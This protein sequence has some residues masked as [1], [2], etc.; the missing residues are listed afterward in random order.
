MDAKVVAISKGN[1]RYGDALHFM[2]KSR[3]MVFFDVEKNMG[4]RAK[5]WSGT[6]S[7][8]LSL[9]PAE[10]LDDFRYLEM[11]SELL[12]NQ[13][14]FCVAIPYRPSCFSG[15][16]RPVDGHLHRAVSGSGPAFKAE[17]YCHDG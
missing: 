12:L 9:D 16:S 2:K 5:D 14:T 13:E 1:E 11:N 8:W 10:S 17:H 15:E 3:N 6:V 4:Y 7:V